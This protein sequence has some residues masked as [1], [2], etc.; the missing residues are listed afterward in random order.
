MAD[1]GKVL[2]QVAPGATTDTVLY[3][4]PDE[5]QTTCSSLVVCNRSAGALT[6]RVSVRPKGAAVTTKHYLYYDKSV[7]AN[8]SAAHIIGMTLQE[9]DVVGVYASSGDLSFTLFGV[10]TT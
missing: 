8:D 2:G 4:V 6:Y 3:T 5:T 7:A 1:I 9:N 10:E